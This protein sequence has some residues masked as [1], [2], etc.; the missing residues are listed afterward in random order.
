MYVAQNK[1]PEKTKKRATRFL[2]ENC[3]IFYF[4]IKSTRKCPIF[5]GGDQKYQKIPN[6]LEGDF[7]GIRGNKNWGLLQHEICGRF[8]TNFLGGSQGTKIENF[9][10]F[11]FGTGYRKAF[12]GISERKMIENTVSNLHQVYHKAFVKESKMFEVKFNRRF[13][14][15]FHIHFSKSFFNL[16][17]TR[18]CL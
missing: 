7:R 13:T 12:R 4:Q 11:R 17:E 3:P 1:Q 15:I 2:A 5:L 18:H 16:P 9:F 14:N 6:F 10:N 8:T